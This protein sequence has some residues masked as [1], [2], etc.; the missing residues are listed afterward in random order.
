M[1]VQ[2]ARPRGEMAERPSDTF[3]YHRG[4]VAVPINSQR[5]AAS[6]P[7]A[8]KGCRISFCR[9]GSGEQGR[10][11]QLV[12]TQHQEEGIEHL[13]GIGIVERQAVEPYDCAARLFNHTMGGGGVP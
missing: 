5:L 13:P 2:E 1:H 7:R 6:Q 9:A 10:P 8:D 3:R 4:G 11:V 12:F